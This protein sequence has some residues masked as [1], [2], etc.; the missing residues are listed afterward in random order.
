MQ[1]SIIIPTLNEEQ[2]LPETLRN[3]V[4][5]IPGGE[6]IVVDGGSSDRTREVVREFAALHGESTALCVVWLDAPV[7]RGS[8]M[9]AGAARAMGDTLLF[10]HADSHLPTQTSDMIEAAL[11]SPR[12]LGGFFRIAFIPRTSLTDFYAW[13]YNIRSHFRIFYGDAALFVRR[14]VFER[15]GGYR[16]ALLM[17]DIELI[18][19]LRRA[20]K[21]AYCRRAAVCTSS[22]RFPTTWMGIKMLGVWFW[23]HFL[24]ACG[25]SQEKIARLYPEKR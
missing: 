2:A 17:E 20:G 11:R 5:A 25:V 1:I 23:L 9:N 14:D 16:A 7:G 24:M 15:L 6:V 4:N 8:Q 19:R 18:L 22:R 10:L 3:I 12:V 21:L 13:C